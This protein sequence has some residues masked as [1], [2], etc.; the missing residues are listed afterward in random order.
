MISEQYHRG[1]GKNN[2]VATVRNVLYKYIIKQFN[3]K[4]F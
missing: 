4:Q 2:N 3:I 1:Y